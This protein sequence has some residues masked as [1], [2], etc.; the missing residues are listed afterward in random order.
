M[1]GPKRSEQSK[2]PGLSAGRRRVYAGMAMLLALAALEVGARAWFAWGPEVN[3]LTRQRLAGQVKADWKRFVPQPYLVYVPG[4]GYA[5][6]SGPQHNEQGYRGP[7][8]SLRR[9]PGVARVL[10]MG[11]STT[12]SS[13]VARADQS[14]PAWLQRI[15]AAQLPAGLRGVEVI[16]AGLPSGTTAEILTHWVFKFHLYQPD[17]VVIHTGGN[18]A[19]A[20]ARPGYQPD[21]SHWR[22]PFQ[23]PKPLAPAGRVVLKSRLAAFFLIKLIH[24]NDPR[25]TLLDLPAGQ[26]PPARWFEPDKDP[27]GRVRLR[28]QEIAFLHNLD[29]AVRLMKGQGTKVVLMPFRPAPKHDYPPE[30]LAAMRQNE[31]ILLQIGRVLQV[32]VAP[33]PVSTITPANW[34]DSCHLNSAGS[35]EKATHVAPFVREALRAAL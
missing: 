8:V 14:Y 17:V 18:D 30:V 16:N 15:L 31:D 10:C 28:S 6:A 7:A 27:E 23:V 24:G 32:P 2:G 9:S 11:G 1:K 29:T 26:A 13:R 3:E 5:N 12:Y 4:P 22:G 34:V 21:Y 19:A 33:L 35:E 25:V 20:F